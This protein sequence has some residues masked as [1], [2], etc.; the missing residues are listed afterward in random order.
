RM[1][2]VSLALLLAPDQ[3]LP[4]RAGWLRR[5][6]GADT[7]HPHHSL[8]TPTFMKRMHQRRVWVNTWTVNEVDL[9]PR[10][11]RWGVGMVCSD[12]PERLVTAARP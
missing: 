5:F 6:C 9:L 4:L 2:G 7:L 1:P 8:L 10:L 3:P 11:W 12:V